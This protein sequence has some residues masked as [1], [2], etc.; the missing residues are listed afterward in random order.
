MQRQRFLETSAVVLLILVLQFPIVSFDDG[1]AVKTSLNDSPAALAGVTNGQAY[2]NQTYTTTYQESGGLVVQLDDQG[3]AIGGSL[4]SGIVDFLLLRLDSNGGHLWNRTYGSTNQD[5][6]KSLI[7]CRDGGFA[8]LGDTYNFPG[9]YNDIWLVRTDSSGN[10]LWNA[11]YSGPENDYSVGLVELNDGFMVAGSYRNTTS[12]SWD[13]W[14]IRTNITGGVVW[15]KTYG[16]AI[17]QECIAFTPTSDGGY[18]LA[19]WNQSSIWLL[20]ADSQGNQVWNNTFYSTVYQSTSRFIE[21]E[22]GGFAI[23]GRSG[24]DVLL[25]RADS[26]GNHLWNATYH[27]EGL[28]SYG[29]SL[30]ETSNHGFTL[31]TMSYSEEE[32]KMFQLKSF[33]ALLDSAGVWLMK[34]NSTGAVVSECHLSADRYYANDMVTVREGGYVIAGRTAESDLFLWVIPE[35][36]WVQIPA[37]QVTST[38]SPFA[39]QLQAKSAAPLSWQVNNTNFLIDT[40]GVLRNSTVLEAGVYR[41]RITVTDAVSNALTA[42]IVVTV[43][44]TTTTDGN[45]TL[46]LLAIAGIGGLVV[47]VLVVV[48]ARKRRT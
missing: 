38:S 22:G 17:T 19:G 23:I 48:L 16:D 25:M 11:T 31:L 36:D 44:S 21:V 1:L 37:D 3:Y 30:V 41:L 7:Q 20:K 47:L 5:T 6:L 32:D 40:D 27:R 43:S 29:L 35:L 15:S 12:V 2:I 45:Q 14:L 33:S 42:D 9:T 28:G 4:L 10:Q 13:F 39:Y 8:L 18:A 46:L 34:T 24:N 26:E